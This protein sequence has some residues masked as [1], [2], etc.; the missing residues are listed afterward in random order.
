MT[1]TNSNKQDLIEETIKRYSTR[2]PKRYTY[3]TLKKITDSFKNKLGQGG[4][5]TVYKGKLQDGRDVA[6]KLLNESEDNCQDFINEVISITT[7]SHVNIVTFLGFC[8]ERNKRALIYEYMPKGS[9]DKYICHKGLQKGRIELNWMTLYN[10]IVGVAR[11]LEYLHR[12]C[13]TRILH[14]DIK[15]HNILLDDEF[16]PKISDFGLSKQWKAKESHVSMSGVKGTIGFM[17]PEVVQ[18]RY[19]KVSHKSDV[20]SYGML[21]LEVVGERQSPNK[22]VGDHSEEY[23]PDWI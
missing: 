13:N 9:L 21:I 6:V 20:Y 14:F 17:A 12:G 5:A 15:P 11:G 18:R 19:G 22:G 16:C 10:I 23:F 1:L 3:S 2:I 8:Y 7:T 4:F